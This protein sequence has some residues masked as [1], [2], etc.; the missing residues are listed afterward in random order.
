M[1]PLL[2]IVLIALPQLFSL[3]FDPPELLVVSWH[4]SLQRLCED[5]GVKG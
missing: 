2:A 1:V 4:F 3:M 5:F